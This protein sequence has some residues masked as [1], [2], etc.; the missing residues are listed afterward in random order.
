MTE[1]DHTPTQRVHHVVK[2]VHIEKDKVT[3]ECDCGWHSEQYDNEADARTEFG[4][5][6]EEIN[7]RT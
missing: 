4:A 2:G 5:H 6:Q 7:G 3:I 1:V